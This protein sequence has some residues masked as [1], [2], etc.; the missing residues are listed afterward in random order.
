MEMFPETRK[1][2]SSVASLFNEILVS[3]VFDY[4]SKEITQNKFLNGYYK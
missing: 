2:Y 3:L 4:R 1:N